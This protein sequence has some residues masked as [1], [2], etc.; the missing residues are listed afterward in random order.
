MNRLY[1]SLQFDNADTKRKLGY[2]AKISYEEGIK[3]ML[4][5][6]KK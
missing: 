4:E 3:K 5:K 2:Q 6:E 1:G